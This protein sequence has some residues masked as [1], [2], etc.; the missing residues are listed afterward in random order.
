[1]R[2]LLLAALA[3]QGSYGYQYHLTHNTG[4]GS[5]DDYAQSA[6]VLS[7]VNAMQCNASNSKDN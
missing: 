5:G 4:S 1:M 6:L 2:G 3:A 7:E